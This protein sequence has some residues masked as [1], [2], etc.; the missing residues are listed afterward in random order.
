MNICNFVGNIVPAFFLVITGFVPCEHPF[1]AVAML[2]LSVGFCG[3]QYPGCFVNHADIAAPFA[4]ILFGLSNSC[5]TIPGIIAPY[6]VGVLT[7][8]VSYFVNLCIIKL[9][10]IPKSQK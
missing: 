2:T 3:F 8:N 6:L 9:I 10:Y 1:I 5:A 7:P 4:G